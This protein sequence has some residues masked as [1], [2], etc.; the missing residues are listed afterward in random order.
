[1]LIASRE[2]GYEATKLSIQF[3]AALANNNNNVTV[4]PLLSTYLRVQATVAICE[5]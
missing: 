4:R 3:K 1:M 5:P 2:P